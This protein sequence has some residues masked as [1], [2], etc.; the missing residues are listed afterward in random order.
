[1]LGVVAVDAIIAGLS[2]K[3]GIDAHSELTEHNGY[4]DSAQDLF[5]QLPAVEGAGSSS[6][7]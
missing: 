5:Q 1:V 3:D 4:E 2:V 6:P 7:P